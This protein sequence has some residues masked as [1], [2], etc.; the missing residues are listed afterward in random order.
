MTLLF[1]DHET[2][3]YENS[4][5]QIPHNGHPSAFANGLVAREL[6]HRLFDLP[7]E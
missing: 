3:G 5:L 6:R 1:V 4:E 7:V 2:K